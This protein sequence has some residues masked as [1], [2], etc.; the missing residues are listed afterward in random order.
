MFKFFRLPLGAALV[1]AVSYVAYEFYTPALCLRGVPLRALPR[2]PM[3]VG[4]TLQ[5]RAGGLDILEECDN[6]LPVPVRWSSS[7][8]TVVSV[9]Q[10]GRLLA[11]RPGAADIV[12]QA[13]WASVS[14]RVTIAAANR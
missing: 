5:L 8:S 3:T 7:D 13:R 2:D 14:H 6:A 10:T 9:D 11:L 4:D 1:G 12:I